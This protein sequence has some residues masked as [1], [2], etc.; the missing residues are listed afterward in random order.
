MRHYIFEFRPILPS[1]LVS[2][3]HTL[4]GK[5]GPSDYCNC[6]LLLSTSM[7]V[8]V[9]RQPREG[10]VSSS[11]YVLLSL[12]PE[13]LLNEQLHSRQTHLS[14]LMASPLQDQDESIYRLTYFSPGRILE[15]AATYNV[16]ILCSCNANLSGMQ[17]SNPPTWISGSARSYMSYRAM[18]TARR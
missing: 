16:A 17:T 18:N 12:V 11:G 2:P 13:Y 15:D 9:A 5:P 6:C 1:K 8:V 14:Y 3:T 10:F 7:G 4:R